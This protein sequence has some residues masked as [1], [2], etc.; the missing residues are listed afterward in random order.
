MLCGLDSK[1]LLSFFLA[2]QGKHN[3]HGNNPNDRDNNKQL[4]PTTHTDVMQS[5]RAIGQGG[6]EHD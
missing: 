6:D 5:A 3:Q 1:A 4:P 2:W